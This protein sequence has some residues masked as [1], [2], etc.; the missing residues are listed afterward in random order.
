MGT[1]TTVQGSICSASDGG[2][3]KY[4][5][6]VGL[7]IAVIHPPIR[8]AEINGAS[9]ASSVSRTASGNSSAPI[10]G[11]S[12]V[13]FTSTARNL[14]EAGTQFGKLNIFRFDP[15]TATIRP[16]SAAQDGLTGDGNS[17]AFSPTRNGQYV[18]FASE[19]ANF[20]L[21]DNNRAPDIFV[22][23]L[24]N[25]TTTLASADLTSNTSPNPNPNSALRPLCANPEVADDGRWA[26]FESNGTNLVAFAKDGSG[27]DIFVRDLLSNV[28]TLVS[29]DTNGSATSSSRSPHITPNGRF[30][31]FVSTSTNLISATTPANSHLFRRDLQNGETIWISKPL[32]DLGPHSNF[33]PANY[34]LED[35]I[36]DDGG[37]FVYKLTFPYSSFAWLFRYNFATDES[38]QLTTNAYYRSVVRISPNGRFTAYE[39][40]PDVVVWD[41]LLKTNILVNLDASNSHPSSGVSHSPAVSSN[42]QYVAFLSDA[43]DLVTNATNGRF[44]VYWRD[45]Q[46]GV[47]RLVSRSTNGA[48][49]GA[50]HEFIIPA[51]SDDGLLVAFESDAV[52]L[53]QNDGNDASDVFLYDS[54]T[55]SIRLISSANPTNPARSSRRFSGSLQN[56]LSA[57]GQFLTYF[58][59]DLNSLSLSN[60][61]SSVLIRNL[62]TRTN[63]SIF[64]V[65]NSISNAE[66]SGDGRYVTYNRRARSGG[67]ALHND[68]LFRYDVVTGENVPLTSRL[69]HSFA[70]AGAHVMSY[71][72]SIVAYENANSYGQDVYIY[73]FVSGTNYLASRRADG[74][75][76]SASTPVLSPDGRKLF[77]IGSSQVYMKVATNQSAP[78]LAS[79]TVNTNE[80]LQGA[81]TAVAISGNS[82]FALLSF[83]FDTNRVIYRYDITAN[84]T[85]L[86]CSSCQNASIDSG[87]LMAYET[88]DGVSRIRSVAIRDLETGQATSLSDPAS[89]NLPSGT[90]LDSWSP[91]ITDDARFILFLSRNSSS[92]TNVTRLYVRDRVMNQTLLLTPNAEGIGLVTGDGAQ[93]GVSRDG[94]TAVFR[95][96]ASDLV[97]GDYNDTR[98]VFVVRLGSGDSDGDGMD[99]DW[100]IAYFGNLSRNGLGDFDGDGQ[101]DL[102]E[103]RAG[104]DP[105]NA[106][107]ILRAIAVTPL[108]GKATVVW[109]AIPGR[110]YRVEYKQNVDDPSWAVVSGEVRI[111][112]STGSM[113]DPSSSAD[114][115]RF[116][117]VAVL[118]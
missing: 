101:S 49:A 46:S 44:Q 30:V 86:V 28:T 68:D 53:V 95:S 35:A 108:N 5:A 11:G 81:A 89:L 24:P 26:V 100:E 90:P 78:F 110:S 33:Y 23:N 109:N 105:T 16:V 1:T 20:A 2:S 96:F 91:V 114:T 57:N 13:F 84:A 14:T 6:T 10:F 43:S 79:H 75:P 4:L 45:L 50:N 73:D 22:R 97:S 64:L 29:V 66:I 40:G 52:D 56:A 27:P 17:F 34:Q 102:Q 98:D 32:E 92:A 54:T 63:V 104:T 71:D 94:R 25:E 19:A 118:R 8:A 65:T 37:V 38:E 60:R 3:M 42:G 48:A 87:T 76:S 58:G 117:R 7:V 115:H 51:I 93:L 39:E 21:G 103:F 72:G 77:F 15:I 111:N 41:D 99:D 59:Y 55:D 85:S 113:E 61:L 47:T 67:G 106:G 31:A 82:Q 112:G 74:T 9:T 70:G 62:S 88:A 18:A 12:A 36:S 80:G 116:Y 83:G 107:S 69:D